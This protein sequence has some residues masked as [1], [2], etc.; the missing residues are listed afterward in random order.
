[1]ITVYGIKNCNTMTQAFIWLKGHDVVYDFHD[2]KKQGVDVTILKK[3]I[4]AHG[5]ENVI[6]RKGLTWK[7]LPQDSR[8]TMTKDSAIQIAIEKPSI[9][10]RPLIAKGDEILLGF[11]AEKY[12]QTLL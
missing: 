5:W 2:Y 10:K 8:E 3:A 6:N 7:K 12:K 9:I 1:M 4:D 11:D